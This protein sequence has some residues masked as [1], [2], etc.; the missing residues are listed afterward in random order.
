MTEW[1]AGI[2]ASFHELGRDANGA[3]LMSEKRAWLD[4][5]GITDPDHRRE[6]LALWKGMEA[7]EAEI[8]AER[9]ERRDK[10]PR[11]GKR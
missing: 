11:K 4:E 3:A 2:Y 8:H 5:A 10:Q 7:E 6:Y 1:E 9:R